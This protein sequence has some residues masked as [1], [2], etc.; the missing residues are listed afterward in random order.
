MIRAMGPP[1]QANTAWHGCEPAMTI[2][3]TFFVTGVLAIIVSLLVL[4]WAAA[5][6]QWK[7]GGLVLILLSI[8]Q[9]LVGGGFV[10]VALGII[11]GVAATRIHAPFTWWRR[12]L[13]V[14]TQ[15]FLAMLWPWPLI[16]FV[17]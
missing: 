13:S 6:V 5:F 15:R 11:A 14:Y 10:P 8:I 16:V 2:I 17:V 3:P 4:L 9:L 12:P 7:H 1:C